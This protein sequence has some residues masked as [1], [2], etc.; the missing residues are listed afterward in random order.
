MSPTKTNI[1]VIKTRFSIGE[2]VLYGAHRETFTVFSIEIH[3][4]KKD[5]NVNYLVQSQYGFI[6]RVRENDL[7]KYQVKN[8]K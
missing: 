7:I 5:K 1:M 2:K 8:N 4:G 3:V 6:R